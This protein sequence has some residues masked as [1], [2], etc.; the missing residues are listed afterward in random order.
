[1]IG[2]SH[3]Y[4]I[5]NLNLIMGFFLL[6]LGVCGNYIAETLGCRVRKLLNENM[7]VKNVIIILIIY[8]L[9]G[10]TN[11]N[12]LH[13]KYNI[14]CSLVIWIV[15]LLFNKTPIEFTFIGGLLL[16]LILICKNFI[17]YYEANNKEEN[18]DIIDKLNKVSV[19]LVY[20]LFI[21]I[22]VGFVIYYNQKH[23]EYNNNFS[24][25][26]FIFG[27]VKCKSIK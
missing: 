2:N 12:R 6:L 13:P 14:M 11:D 16:V 27:K 10:F 1:M 23:I 3:K 19:Y 25:T 5:G 4:I 20:S 9:I 15:F 18:K 8:F 17:D 7:Y 22:I 24:I 26:K 21:I